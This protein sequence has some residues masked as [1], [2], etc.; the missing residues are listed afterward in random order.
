MNYAV[1]T[2]VNPLKSAAQFLVLVNVWFL[3]DSAKH[4]GDSTRVCQNADS[5]QF[6]ITN[7]RGRVASLGLL[8]GGSAGLVIMYIIVFF[9]MMTVI[10]SMAEMAS[11]LVRQLI[12]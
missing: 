2:Q 7:F 8:N 4:L 10:L 12:C 5:L 11:M 6:S 1:E 3:D 9:G